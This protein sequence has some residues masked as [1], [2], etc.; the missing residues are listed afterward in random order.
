MDG[1]QPPRSGQL[2]HRSSLPNADQVAGHLQ[3]EG[4]VERVEEGREMSERAVPSPPPPS[5]LLAGLLAS[6]SDDGGVE[7]GG[8]EREPPVSPRGGRRG[9]LS[10]LSIITALS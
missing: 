5:S 3:E 1:D 2:A 9:G 4:G 10:L 6:C 8:V 7:L